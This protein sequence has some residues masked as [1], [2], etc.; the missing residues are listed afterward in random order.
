MRKECKIKKEKIQQNK[1]LKIPR[2]M[3]EE[4]NKKETKK[5]WKTGKLDMEGGVGGSMTRLVGNLFKRLT[6]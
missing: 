1:T 4:H 6:L 2:G 3:A 5:G